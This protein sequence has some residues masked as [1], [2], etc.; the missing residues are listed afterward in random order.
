MKF[1][2]NLMVCESHH[3]FTPLSVSRLKAYTHKLSVKVKI[4]STLWCFGKF[5]RTSFFTEHLRL[6]LLSVIL[7]HQTFDRWSIAYTLKSLSFERSSMFWFKGFAK[8]WKKLSQESSRIRNSGTV[9]SLKE[10][11]WK[12]LQNFLVNTCDKSFWV[13]SCPSSVKKRLAKDCQVFKSFLVSKFLRSFF[14]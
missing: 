9:A 6:L 2:T 11:L 8:W 10:L 12:F 1:Q 14:V 3:L 13:K 7:S 4:S 5:L